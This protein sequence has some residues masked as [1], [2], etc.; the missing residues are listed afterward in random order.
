[1]ET[2]SP[3]EDTFLL[4]DILDRYPAK[5]S[6]EIGVGRGLITTALAKKS[7]YVVGVDISTE[8]IK[9]TQRVLAKLELLQHVD[10]V[11]ADGPPPLSQRTFDLI[12]FNPPYLPSENIV[13][14]RVDGGERGIDVPIRWFTSCLS[15][16]KK[17]G[18]VLMILSTASA[19][20]LAISR[21]SR[22]CHVRIVARQRLFFEELLALEITQQD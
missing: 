14:R 11:I 4:A 20:D 19:F 2:Y 8:A 21:I 7:D 1:M 3:S 5:Q 12:V 22:T 16:I 6:L 15:L 18:T 10:L 13:D 17:H 9:E